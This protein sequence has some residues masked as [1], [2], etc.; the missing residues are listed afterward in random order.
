MNELMIGM[1]QLMCQKID[2]HH[3]I[4]IGIMVIIDVVL[5]V[6]QFESKTIGESE[7]FR[8]VLLTSELVHFGNGIL[9]H[10]QF[11]SSITK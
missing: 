8:H 7:G 11:G 5:G 10:G 6:G 1:R 2:H 9:W 4:V 3:P